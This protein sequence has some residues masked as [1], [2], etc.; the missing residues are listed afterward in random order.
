MAKKK[1][2]NIADLSFEE[3]VKELEQAAAKLESSELS[4]EDSI[5][6]FARSMNI[7]RLAEEKIQLAEKT[8]EQ[9]SENDNG[10]IEYKEF[11]GE[12]N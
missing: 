8:V 9:L 5:A 10:K 6:M 2:D 11:M 7:S 3:L 4:L 12:D 1:I